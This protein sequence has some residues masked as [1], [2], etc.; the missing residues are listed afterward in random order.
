MGKHVQDS[1]PGLAGNHDHL[2]LALALSVRTGLP[3]VGL[4]MT[5][6]RILNFHVVRSTRPCQFTPASSPSIRDWGSLFLRI[7]RS[8][9]G[10]GRARR[11]FGG[12]VSGD[13]VAFFPQVVLHRQ[14]GIP[15]SSG[16]GPR[17][18]SSRRLMVWSAQSPRAPRCCLA[19]Y[20]QDYPDP[21]YYLSFTQA[22][23]FVSVVRVPPCP[24]IGAG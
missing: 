1:A 21:R 8:D 24:S 7:D 12:P 5:F 16:S 14:E 10:S 22:T 2:R 18:A 20:R 19:S 13:L 9:S 15:Q 23:V 3:Q 17:A 4:C 6:N 11:V